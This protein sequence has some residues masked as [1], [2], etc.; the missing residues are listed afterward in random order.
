MKF[1]FFFSHP[2]QY[3]TCR[4]TVKRLATKEE[5]R[6]TVLIKSKDVLEEL[7]KQDKMEF[8]NIQPRERGASKSAMMLGLLKSMMLVLPIVLRKKPDLLIGT[9]PVLAHIGFLLGI[10]RITILEDDYAV[11][12]KM[13]DILYPFTQTIL[14]PEV[15]DVGKWHAK[16]VGYEG[17]MK[18]GYLHPSVFSIDNSITNK[19]KIGKEFVLIRLSKLAAYHDVGIKGIDQLLLDRIIKLVLEKG[20]NLYITSE[21][22]MPE[23]YKMYQL[24]IEPADMHHIL[25]KAALLISDSQ[26]MSVEAAMLG[27]PSVRYS[28]LVG[29]LSVL[30]EL[31][32]NYALTH[33]IPAGNVNK[34]LAKIN[35][36]LSSQNL[37][38]DFKRKRGKMLSEKIDLT[39]FLVWFFEN[40]PGSREKMLENRKVVITS[41]NKV[42]KNKIPIN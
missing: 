38:A 28:S 34:L 42:T 25:A 20:Y 22:I 7:I 29:R 8:I 9:A 23:Q 33:G 41:L 6:V 13:A 26:S 37:H 40:Y 1:L 4:E 17:Y 3:L 27:V 32:K 15:C 35:E 11:I 39:P 16:K 24:P 36:L 12:K 31:E 2:A 10:D 19:Y 18:L 21:G 5:H 14:C 30:N